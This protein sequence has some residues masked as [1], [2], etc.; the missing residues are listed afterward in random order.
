VSTDKRTYVVDIDDTLLVS[1][2]R[3]CKHCKSMIYFDCKPVV[4]EVKKVNRL[5][6]RGNTIILWTGR[7]WN[8]Y[9]LTV[10]QLKE[11]GILYH[12]LIMGKPQGVYVDKDAITKLEA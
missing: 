9:D 7:N 2:K 6:R 4:E 8:C 3:R 5:H 10:K 1:K 12:E 11:C